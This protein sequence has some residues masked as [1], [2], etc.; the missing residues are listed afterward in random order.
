KKDIERLN[1][2]AVRFSKI[3]AIP[4]LKDQDIVTVISGV[5]GYLEDRLP[6][7]SRNITFSLETSKDEIILP[8]NR[9]LFEWVFE[10]L[11]KNAVEAIETQS[12]SIIVN[13]HSA[14]KTRS[15]TI[16]V[17]DTGK[18]LVGKQKKDIFRPGYSTKSRGWGLVLPLAKRI[19][20]EY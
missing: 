14:E 6:R 12:G 3:G 9:E 15:V 1:R 17:T 4:D 5:M 2:I 11:I 16:D 8:I 10:N 18:G 13:I 7:L 20:E 19:L